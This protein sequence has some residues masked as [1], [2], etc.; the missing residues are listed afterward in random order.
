LWIE[1]RPGLDLDD[2]RAFDDKIRP[3]APNGLAEVEELKRDLALDLKAGVPEFDGEHTPVGGFE[4]AE[5]EGI[6]RAVVSRV[7]IIILSQSGSRGRGVRQWFQGRVSG[8][9]G[10]SCC[11]GASIPTFPEE[12]KFGMKPPCTP[13]R[14]LFGRDLQVTR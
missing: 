9:R 1:R 2:Q 5:P 10:H 3:V 12:P 7:T 4:K 6:I 8:L 11:D 13:D 14:L